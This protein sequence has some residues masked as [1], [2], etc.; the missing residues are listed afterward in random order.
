M[1]EDNIRAARLM[2]SAASE[3]SQ[4]ARNLDDIM[5]RHQAFLDDWLARYAALLD[6]HRPP[7]PK[8][9][10]VTGPHEPD[11]NGWQEWGGGFCPVRGPSPYETEVWVRLR[12]GTVLKGRAGGVQWRHFNNTHQDWVVAWQ[13]VKK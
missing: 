9:E 8:P 2:A 10:P 5:T 4:A 11:P 12:N 3:V 6:A 1:S 13:L 7:E